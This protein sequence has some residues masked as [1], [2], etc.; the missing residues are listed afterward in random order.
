M[1]PKISIYGP[2]EILLAY[3]V[4]LPIKEIPNEPIDSARRSQ[5]FIQSRIEL[6]R[7]GINIQW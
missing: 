7:R 1:V 2:Q 5:D 6:E 3:Q 4:L